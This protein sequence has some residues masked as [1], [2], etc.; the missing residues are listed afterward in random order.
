MNTVSVATAVREAEAAGAEM[1]KCST[2]P[3]WSQHETEARLR[4]NEPS[5]H[6][7]GSAGW[8]AW[9]DHQYA[10]ALMARRANEPA[11]LTTE[12]RRAQEAK[13]E[14]E[15]ISHTVG[16][17]WIPAESVMRDKQLYGGDY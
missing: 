14:A 13:W 10:L 4:G 5:Y 11:P 9:R 2:L 16:A 17:G 15:R 7:I 1:R 3:L 6:L 12:Q 8:R